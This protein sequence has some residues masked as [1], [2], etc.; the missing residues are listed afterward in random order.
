[1]EDGAAPRSV[2]EGAGDGGG[3]GV[4]PSG[5]AADGRYIGPS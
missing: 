3:R 2:G 4:S 1:M 5:G